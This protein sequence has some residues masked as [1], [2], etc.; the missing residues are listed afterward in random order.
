MAISNALRMAEDQ[1]LNRLNAADRLTKPRTDN[2][3]VQHH[4][5]WRH[6]GEDAPQ[7]GDAYKQS[8]LL[9]VH[10]NQLLLRTAVD[11]A[12][13]A[14]LIE[15]A[16]SVALRKL[17]SDQRDMLFQEVD[18]RV[19]CFASIYRYQLQHG[20]HMDPELL[21]WHQILLGTDRGL[22][23]GQ[24]TPEQIEACAKE[25]QMEHGVTL[26]RVRA[27]LIDVFRLPQGDPSSAFS[28]RH[29]V[30]DFM[31]VIEVQHATSA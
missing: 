18:E 29:L 8:Q 12:A 15:T 11:V 13:S 28:G 4:F 22:V 26:V 10:N 6:G 1:P 3:G 20:S 31:K 9:C 5:F 17:I 23:A 24:L 14:D 27:L 16:Q 7:C 30:D 2:C 25:L 21:K 19:I